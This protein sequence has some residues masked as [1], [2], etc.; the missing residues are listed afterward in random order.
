MTSK[1]LTDISVTLFASTQ[2]NFLASCVAAV[3]RSVRHAEGRGRT[4]S[5]TAILASA[6]PLTRRVAEHVLDSRWKVMDLPGANRSQ[7]RNAARAA[8]LGRFV[9]FVD[10]DD[11]WCETWLDA[12]CQAA[13]RRVAV[14]RPELLLTFGPD[15]H[16]ATGAG[17]AAIF[18]PSYLTDASVL[19]TQDALPSGF[20]T[21]REVL[22]SHPWPEMQPECG[23]LAV[24]RWWNCE[25]AAAEAE[26][27]AVPGTFHYR[28]RH[29]AFP[30]AQSTCPN[31]EQG[32]IGPTGLA[33]AMPMHHA[34][35]LRRRM[36]DEA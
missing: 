3:Q 21:P 8:A 24:D 33:G 13:S 2:G 22:D 19:L 16:S 36:P 31:P 25:V 14:W 11:L 28:R 20:L 23:W 15:F 6:T 34:G 12:A 1:V 35:S 32:R 26:H 9:A 10:A 4:V 18:Q 29:D 5:L 7:A 17:Y 30:G 27:R